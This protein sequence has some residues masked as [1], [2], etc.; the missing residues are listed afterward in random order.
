MGDE[1]EAKCKICAKS[2][3]REKLKKC[4]CCRLHATIHNK[5]CNQNK[6]EMKF[7]TNCHQH[8]AYQIKLFE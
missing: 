8:M 5:E 3:R 1:E 7:E 6:T 4:K 2:I